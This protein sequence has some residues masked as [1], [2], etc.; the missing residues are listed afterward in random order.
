MRLSQGYAL[1]FP[2][3]EE[4]DHDGA[5]VL[6]EFGQIQAAPALSPAGD[7]SPERLPRGHG[8]HLFANH[9]D[10]TFLSLKVRFG[11]CGR[12]ILTRDPMAR[13]KRPLRAP[14]PQARKRL[15]TREARRNGVI[16]VRN[17]FR[18]KF[19]KAREAKALMKEAAAMM[20]AAA[21]KPRYLTDVTGPF[22][23]LVME[24]TYESLTAM[25]KDNQAM[26]DPRWG[27]WY[28]KFGALCDTGSR[29]I[30]TIED[31]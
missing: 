20:P 26:S 5:E 7:L 1:Q 6:R 17:I 16:L 27:A 25:E 11:A 31:I 22:Y 8:T 10:T 19:G 18:L 2:M 4:S 24:T 14:R 13:M 15:A 28:Q 29:E 30:F 12:C 21:P 3:T 23:T 9:H